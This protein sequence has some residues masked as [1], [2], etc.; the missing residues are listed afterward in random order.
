MK[1][2]SGANFEAATDPYAFIQNPWGQV[3]FGIQKYF[4]IFRKVM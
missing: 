3:S 1:K 2:N 4:G